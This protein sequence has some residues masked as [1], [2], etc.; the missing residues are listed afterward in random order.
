MLPGCEQNSTWSLVYSAGS[1]VIVDRKHHTILANMDALAESKDASIIGKFDLVVCNYVFEHVSRPFLGVVALFKLLKPSGL[2]FFAV[3]FNEQYHLVPGDF[4]RYTFDGARE[5]LISA[6]F[7]II[8]A[9]HSA[10]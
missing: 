10:M 2:L 6:G 5:L 7:K 3:P 8:Q 9:E 1:K 4:Y